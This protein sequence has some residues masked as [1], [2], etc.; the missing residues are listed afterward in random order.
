MEC[1][2]RQKS[3][4]V[5]K[6]TRKTATTFVFL[7]V[8]RNVKMEFA[9][10][11]KY[12]VVTLDMNWIAQMSTFVDQSALVGV[13]MLTVQH[14]NPVHVFKDMRKVWIHQNANQFVMSVSIQTVLHLMNALVTLD[15]LKMK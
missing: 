14:L 13:Q 15:S 9:A 6:A 8:L 7:S 10:H 11:L 3:A 1:A 12:V 5:T 2:Q 4:L